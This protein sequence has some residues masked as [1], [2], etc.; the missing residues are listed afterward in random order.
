LHNRGL[1]SEIRTPE[2][3][4]NAST[5]QIITTVRSIDD[6]IKPFFEL[7]NSLR[8]QRANVAENQQSVELHLEIFSPKILATWGETV[9]AR[10]SLLRRG[11]MLYV[12]QL[13][14]INL[15]DLTTYIQNA[16]Q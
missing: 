4:Q 3:I 14:F 2:L 1:E 7:T 9:K 11:E 6:L 12:Q 13:T 16:I 10:I 5:D 8:I 15:P